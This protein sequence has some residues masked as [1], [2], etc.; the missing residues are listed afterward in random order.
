MAIYGRSPVQRYVVA[1]LIAAVAIGFKYALE[2]TIGQE[3][4]FLGVFTAILISA[5]FGGAGP[6][7]MTTAICALA[8]WFLWLPPFHSWRVGSF[9]AV[10]QSVVFL[11][12]GG[13][14]SVIV[15]SID[16][17]RRSARET[18]LKAEVLRDVSD[19]I[20]DRARGRADRRDAL[21]SVYQDDSGDPAAADRALA[22][23]TSLIGAEAAWLMEPDAS[24]LSLRPRATADGDGDGPRPEVAIDSGSAEVRAYREGQIVAI[25]AADGPESCLPVPGP[26]GPLGV[27]IVRPDRRRSLTKED[28]DFLVSA[29]KAMGDLLARSA[30]PAPSPGPSPGPSRGG[31]RAE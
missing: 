4:P 23:I 14:V 9:R 30:P 21:L 10:G 17:A 8:I 6:G 19:Q 11:V 25:D 18:R 3:T 22:R 2:G 31:L 15:A 5:W 1:T 24:G 7:L 16:E 26:T 27:L 20:S 29:A 13:V 28:R 12:E